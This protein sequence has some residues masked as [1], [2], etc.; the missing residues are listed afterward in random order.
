MEI[1]FQG[2][3]LCG[4]E[5]FENKDISK[6]GKTVNNAPSRSH[7]GQLDTYKRK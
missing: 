2:L 5:Y 1:T 3:K 4:T 7:G 6:P